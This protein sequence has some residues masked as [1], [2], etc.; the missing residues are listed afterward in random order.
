MSVVHVTLSVAP[1]QGF[2]RGDERLLVLLVDAMRRM[3][4]FRNRGGEGELPFIP[5]LLEAFGAPGGER[6]P[7]GSFLTCASRWLGVVVRG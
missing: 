4:E 3:R 6:L 1:P 2:A 5:S 7:F